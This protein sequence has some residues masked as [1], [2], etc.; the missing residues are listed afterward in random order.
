MSNVYNLE[1]HFDSRNSFYGKA[2]VVV[3]DDGTKTLYSYGTPV[4]KKRCNRVTLG[5]MFDCSMTTL[6]HV[7]EALRQWGYVPMSKKEIAK[8]FEYE[9]F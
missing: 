7:K 8:T 5:D 6:R 9:R 2:V 1:P 3:A 4:V